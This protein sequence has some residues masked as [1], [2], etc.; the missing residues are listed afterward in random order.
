L[1]TNPESN[2]KTK[3]LATGQLETIP[4]VVRDS[5]ATSSLTQRKKAQDSKS[6][7]FKQVRGSD[8]HRET[9]K[10]EQY[11]ETQRSRAQKE[12]SLK[13]PE[14]KKKKEVVEL[15]KKEVQNK[16]EPNENR[17][18]EEKDNIQEGTVPLARFQ[19]VLEENNELRAEN[20]KLKKRVEQMKKEFIEMS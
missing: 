10:L 1:E 7:L 9:N 5:K 12:E 2:P 17:V 14:V 8:T 3:L 20:E 6:S 18:L 19:E 11:M 4:E 13:S 15:E 16:Q